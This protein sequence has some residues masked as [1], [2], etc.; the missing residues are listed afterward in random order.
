MVKLMSNQINKDQ[1]ARSILATN[2]SDPEKLLE[3]FEL[4]KEDLKK[5]YCHLYYALLGWKD[6]YKNQVK[7]DTLFPKSWQEMMI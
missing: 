4:Y 6:T 3:I 5:D 2:K 7:D 1:I